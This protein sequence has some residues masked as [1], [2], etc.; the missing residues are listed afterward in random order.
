MPHEL[1]EKVSLD[2]IQKSPAMFDKERLTWMNGLLIRQMPVEE[3]LKRCEG[4][5]P[6]AATT[7]SDEYRL[8]ALKLV[9]ERLKFLSELPE[10]TDFFFTEPAPAVTDYKFSDKLTR[11]T[12]VSVLSDLIENLEEQAKP[13]NAPNIETAV[14]E[15]VAKAVDKPG[16]MFM[17]LRIALTGKTAT[18]GLFETM[19]VLGFE[20]TLRR[21]A[22]ARDQFLGQ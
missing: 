8:A 4:F 15:M 18:P 17:I 6:A 5:W 9:Q 21:L 19:E 13:F 7:S 3:L 2:R 14:R 20:L 12:A 1:I 10:L 11:E 22:A 16:P